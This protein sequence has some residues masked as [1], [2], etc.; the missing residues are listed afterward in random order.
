M[1]KGW[2]GGS[3]REWRRI[4]LAVLRRDSYVCQVKIAGICKY[5]ADCVHHLYGKAAGD[6][7][8]NLVASCT[9]CNLHVGDPMKPKRGGGRTRRSAD[10]KPR[11]RTAWLPD[12]IESSRNSSRVTRTGYPQGCFPLPAA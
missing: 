7:P 10:P 5:R 6:N 3:T 2:E 9:P 8:R 4:R 1:S 12:V 11:P